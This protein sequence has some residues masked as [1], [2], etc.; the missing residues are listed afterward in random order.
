MAS[1]FDEEKLSEV[2]ALFQ[3]EARYWTQ[4]VLHINTIISVRLANRGERGQSNSSVQGKAKH[5]NYSMET[6]HRKKIIEK[7]ILPH[8]RP[9]IK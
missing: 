6:T 3:V 4:Y 8:P 5:L 9:Q 1:R 7:Q 2:F